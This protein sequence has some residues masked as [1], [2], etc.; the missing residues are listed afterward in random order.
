MKVPKFKYVIDNFTDFRIIR[1]KVPDFKKLSLKEKKLIYYLYQAGL[2]GRDIYYDQNYKHNLII[3]KTLEEIVKEPKT[4]KSSRDYNQLLDYLK[5]MWASNGIHN[6]YSFKKIVPKF[7][8]AYLIKEIKNL[9]ENKLPLEKKQ[10]LK[11]IIPIVFNK[12]IDSTKTCFDP[13]KDLIKNSAVN[14]YDNLTQKEVDNYYSKLINKK[15][16]EPVMYGLNSM[17]VKKNGKIVEKVW[18]VNGLYSKAIERIIDYLEKAILVS[19]SKQKKIVIKNLIDFYKTGDLKTFDKYSLSW[20]KDNK[21]NVD[22]LNGF[23]ENYNDPLNKKGSYEAMVSIKD[24]DETK[25]T[26]II[27]NNALWFEQNSPTDKEFKRTEIKGMDAKVINVVVEVGDASPTTPIGINLP[28]S[29]WIRQKYGSKSVSLGNIIKAYEM[30]S[31]ESNLKKEFFNSKK[32]IDLLDKYSLLANNLHVDLHEIVGHGSG[33]SEEGMSDFTSSLRN[34]DAVIEE[35][36]ADLV[37]LYFAIDKKLIDLKLM[38]SL[39]VGKALY[40]SYITG[41]LLV[42]LSKIKKNHNLEE[43][44]MRNRQLICKWVYEKGKS[45][46][47]IEKKI[48]NK[49]T[50]FVINDYDRLRELFGKLLKE[51]QRIK[52]TGD[53]NEAKELVE[54][55]GVKVDKKLHAEVIK[56][57]EKLKIPKYSGFINPKLI[58]I[59]SKNKKEIIDVKISYPENFEKQMLEYSYVYSVL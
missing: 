5:Q 21:S 47:I 35:A 38:S 2:Y 57:W 43:A 46:K 22:F 44:H 18:K 24:F 7:S 27:S 55:Y 51:I 58:P 8:K 19:D 10:L 26:K 1:Y 31:K 12:K 6:H 45:Q 41:G 53:Y 39:D 32:E 48:K 11:I 4:K 14:F 28:N 50:Y 40:I 25:R 33:K 17:L 13:K 20:L 54:K 3:R 29:N 30:A 15:D 52:S 42:Q 16:K 36:R 49:K 23:I 37:A 59:Y 9:E 56:R 34:Y